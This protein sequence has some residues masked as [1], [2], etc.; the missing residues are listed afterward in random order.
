[1]ARQA[2]DDEHDTAPKDWW[3]SGPAS[4]GACMCHLG[5]LAAAAVVA[6]RPVPAAGPDANAPAS[7]ATAAS[8]PTAATS[9]SRTATDA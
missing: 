5:V 4:G 7:P 2:E 1:M 3:S 6:T 9:V 8:A